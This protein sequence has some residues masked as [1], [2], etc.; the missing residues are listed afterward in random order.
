MKHL[1][2]EMRIK[3]SHHVFRK[4]WIEEK[5][6]LQKKGNK[7][8]PYGA[9]GDRFI[10]IAIVDV[11]LAFQPFDSDILLKIILKTD[12]DGKCQF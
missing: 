1:G 7:E 9:H 8:K 12:R 2:F 10:V 6:N 4:I 5:T 11:L 3:G